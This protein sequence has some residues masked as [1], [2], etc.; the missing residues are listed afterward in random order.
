MD[1]N[2]GRPVVPDDHPR[3]KSLH[4]RHV[5]VDGVKNR[6]VTPSG[7][8]AHG[9]G[10]A[11]DYILGEQTNNEA[12]KAMEAAVATLLSANHPVISVNGNVAALVPKEIV[13]FSNIT[14]IPLEV[15][16]FYQAPGRIKAISNL[17]MQSG[18][19]ELLG[20]GDVNSVQISNLTSNRRIVDP[21]GIYKADVVLV[22]LEDGDRT[23]ALVAEGKTVICIDLNPLSRTAQ[24]SH[25]TI[26]DNLVR[27]I[28]TMITIAKEFR[29]YEPSK[30]QEII[31]NYNHKENLN[32]ILHAI[33]QY[34]KDQ[35]THLE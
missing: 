10:E 2:D 26:V 22:P 30:L 24:K 8:C 31:K 20:M 4:Y 16:I 33:I 25:I 5:L 18:A 32:Q 1:R 34:L 12:Y 35:I 6:V 27:A 11:F 28:P 3:A 9:R 7:L 17:L 21:R 13:E 29:T 23:E 19:K 15:N 14:Q